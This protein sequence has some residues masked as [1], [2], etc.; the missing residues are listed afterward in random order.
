MK[1]FLYLVATDQ[2]QGGI[3]SC[4][5]GVLWVLSKIYLVLIT[6]RGFVY[7]V[8]I[9]K[10]HHLS[11]PVVSVGNLTMGGVGKTPLVEFIARALK[12]RNIQPVVLMRGYM[13]GRADGQ[14]RGNDE[15]EML[16]GSLADIPILVGADRVRQA[17][18]FLKANTVGTFL[19]DDGFQHW[20]LARDVDIV[21]V[22]ATNPWGNG[23][24]LPRG[25]LREPKQALSRAHIFV[26]TKTDLA[27][28]QIE[29]L[30]GYLSAVNPKALLVESVHNPV[31]FTDLRS[32]EDFD[33]AS[34]QGEAIVS[35]CSIGAPDSFVRTLDKLGAKVGGHLPFM[36]H[37]VYTSEDVASVVALCKEKRIMTV[38]T[39]EKDAVK[40]KPFMHMLPDD[41]R[42]L[43]LKI[44]I[45]IVTGEDQFLERIYHLL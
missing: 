3:V 4:V 2:I 32:G 28:A 39:T 7:K 19:L 31:S 38:V 40:L 9:L 18:E 35:V 22:D 36:D 41:I 13:E 27:T 5:K 23:H 17:K 34:T 21:M 24:V 14:G 44:K 10:H 16:R 45:S 1:R 15:S 11:V 8:G 6:L 43:S 33:L 29:E 37:H 26:V 25:I 12:E 42:V 30:K 20:R